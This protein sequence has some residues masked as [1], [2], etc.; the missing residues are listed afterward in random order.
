M[1]VRVLRFL[2]LG[3]VL[4]ALLAGPSYS[5]S[6][7]VCVPQCTNGELCCRTCGS[8]VCGFACTQ[9]VDGHCPYLP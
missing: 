8:P 6:S 9:P 2:G 3:V 4:A 5:Q 1:R 7:G